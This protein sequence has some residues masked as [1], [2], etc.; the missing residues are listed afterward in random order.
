MNDLIPVSSILVLLAITAGIFAVFIW[1]SKVVARVTRRLPLFRNGKRMHEDTGWF[2]NVFVIT[3][4]GVT[5]WLLIA[6]RQPRVDLLL[7]LKRSEVADF[8]NLM[9]TL[10]SIAQLDRI[11]VVFVAT[12]VAML[13]AGIPGVRWILIAYCGLTAAIYTLPLTSL[14]LS[15]ASGYKEGS[16][17]LN[18]AGNLAALGMQ[19]S[20]EVI[21]YLSLGF[22]AVFS[23]GPLFVAAQIAVGVVLCPLVIAFLVRYRIAPCALAVQQIG[24]DSTKE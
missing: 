17:D 18:A 16:L 10:T 1:L 20:T 11:L 2:R 5:L 12:M 24:R 8:G 22:F 9:I 21:P 6:G 23:K 7:I 3:V 19:L 4:V 15:L 13:Y 14:L